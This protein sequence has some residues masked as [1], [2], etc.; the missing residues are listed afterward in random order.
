MRSIGRFG[1]FA[2]LGL[3]AP[4]CSGGNLGGGGGTG[5]TGGVMTGEGPGNAGR[6]GPGGMGGSPVPRELELPGCLQD[7]LAPCAP[8]GV[9]VDESLGPESGVDCFGNGTRASWGYMMEPRACGVGT[10]YVHVNKPD[11][12]FCYRYEAYPDA[13][14]GCEVVQHVWKDAAGNVVASGTSSTDFSVNITCTATGEQ[15]ACSVP[16]RSAMEPPCCNVSFLGAASCNSGL[17]DGSCTSGSCSTTGRG[18]MGGSAGRGGAGGSTGM[19]GTTGAAQL[20]LPDCVKN[21]VAP[22]ATSGACKVEAIDAGAAKNTCYASGVQVSQSGVVYSSGPTT[23]KTFSVT[24]ADGSPCYSLET[25]LIGGEVYRYVWKDA[26]GEVVAT[27]SDDRFTN[28]TN[29]ITCANGGQTRTCH[30]PSINPTGA[31]C[32]LNEFG[33]ATCSNSIPCPAGTCP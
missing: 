7:L 14:M 13:S 2:A 26:A 5:G 9:C 24:K 18:G 21:L 3:L 28:P 10:R 27:G 16:F 19:G 20:E 12:T 4:A 29:T 30:S 15:A 23:V 11:G 8:Q 17:L 25:S 22:C 33:N 31:C 32:T 6:G 1:L